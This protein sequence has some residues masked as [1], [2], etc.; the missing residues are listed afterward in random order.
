M[1]NIKFSDVNKRLKTLSTIKE[2][3]NKTLIEGAHIISNSGRYSDITRCIESCARCNDNIPFTVYMEL[4]DALSESNNLSNINKMGNYIIENIVHKVRDP[5]QTRELIRRKLGRLKTK[6]KPKNPM[7]LLKNKINNISKPPKGLVKESVDE[8]VYNIY[9]SMLEEVTIIENCDR[10]IENYNN[11]SKRFNLDLFFDENARTNGIPDTVIELCKLIDTYTMSNAIKFNTVI[12]TAWYGFESNHIPYNKSDILE[13]AVDYF[14][15]KEDG[16]ESCKNILDVTMFYDKEDMKNVDVFIE[17]E[18][19]EEDNTSDN[20]IEEGIKEYCRIDNIRESGNEDFKFNKLFNKFKKDEL[21]KDDKP[22]NKLKSLISKLYTNSVDGIIEGT[23]KLLSWIRTFF[24]LGTIS[25]PVVGPVLTAVTFIADRFISLHLE[26]D[27]VNKMIKCFDNEIKTTKEKIKNTTDSEEKENLN[28]Y[29]K[30]LN[31]GRSKIDAYY[32]T[33]LTDKEQT[34]K[35]SIG[36]SDYDDDYSDD[37]NMDDFD[38]LLEYSRIQDNMSDAITSFMECGYSVG[39]DDMYNLIKNVDDE[40]ITDIAK[41]ASL[42]PEEFYKDKVEQSVRDSIVDIDKGI[43]KFESVVNKVVRKD[44]LNNALSILEKTSPAPTPKTIEEANEYLNTVLEAFSAIAII[45]ESTNDKK[46]GNTV[47]EASI[48]NTLKMGI[49]KLRGA[50]NKMSDKEKEVSREIDRGANQM[51]RG[52]EKALTTGNR[53]AVIKGSVIPSA[54]KLIKL[55]IANAG[56]ILLTHQPI[57]AIIATLGYFG[58]SNKFKTKERQMVIDEIEIELK[59]CEKYIALAE[60]KDDMQALKQL[61]TIQRNLERQHQRIKYKMKVELSR[62]GM[63]SSYLDKNKMP[64][65]G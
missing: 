29:L 35:Y 37:F 12:E 2:T 54:S 48:T 3:T 50:L 53:E 64:Y 39:E 24:I 52:V 56:I 15:F 26:R 43:M 36:S 58:V 55:C 45:N 19:T 61:L 34:E 59:M 44:T 42:Y 57:A 49:M 14:L 11:I 47:L 7:D 63:D 9:N 60:Q 1:R 33:L 18:P 17:D 20:M 4:F 23:P 46:S 22:Q 28:K 16:A 5:K 40:A 21:A 31:D 30:S 51:L 62:K 27:E 38:D 13:S 6:L 8:Q 32:N 10:V 41:L 25:V 65:S